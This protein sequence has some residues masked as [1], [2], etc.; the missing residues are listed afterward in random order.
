M[1]P[2]DRIGTPDVQIDVDKVVAVVETNAEDRNSPFKP[3]DDDSK[4]I[5]GYLLDYLDGGVKAGRLPEN[6]LPMQSGVG[7]IPN[8]VLAVLLDSKDENL[9]SFTEVIHDGTVDLMDAGKL[10]VASGT[11]FSLSPEYAARMSENAD[12]CREKIVLRPQ[13]ISNNPGLGCRLIG[14]WPGMRGRP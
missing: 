9:T 4:A 2:D 1:N 5:A 14:G 3:L 13:D 7:N 11:A 12:D 10:T 8:A 6:L